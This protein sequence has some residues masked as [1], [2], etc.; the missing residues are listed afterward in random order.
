M[1]R[2]P[3][4]RDRNIRPEPFRGA[5][6]DRCR[7]GSVPLSDSPTVNGRGL[8]WS[9]PA[10]VVEPDRARVPVVFELAND[11]EDRG[12]AAAG[13]AERRDDECAV[14]GAAKVAVHNIDERSS[15][16]AI[17][18]GDVLRKAMGRASCDTYVAV[19]VRPGR[20]SLE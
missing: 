2:V 14:K 17:D 5:N 20:S 3:A 13:P 10:W 7:H 12:V 4:G 16:L 9:W 18:T 11:V 19:T 8:T 1:D 15:A 6:E